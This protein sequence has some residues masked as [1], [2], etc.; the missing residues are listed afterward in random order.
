MNP[1]YCR[2]CGSKL[3]KWNY[4]NALYCG[5]KCRQA[6]YDIDK[7]RKQPKVNKKAVEGVRT[8]Q[9]DN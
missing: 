6:R 9:N 8:I 5:N 7:A 2:V 1:Y 4:A 3:D